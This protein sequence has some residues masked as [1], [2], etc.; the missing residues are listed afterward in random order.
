VTPPNLDPC[1]DRLQAP[2]VAFTLR[3]IGLVHAA[4][5]RGARIPKYLVPKG[6]ATLEVFHPY[7]PGL[8]GLYAGS[9]V[10]VVTWHA[11]ASRSHADGWSDGQ[12]LLGVFATSSVERPNPLEFQRARVVDLDTDK[13][14]LRV[15]GL[16]AEDGAPILDIR[17]ALTPHHRLDP[18]RG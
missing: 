1:P 3:P 6:R 11:P 8:Q 13:G 12:G 15:E 17:P 10:W 18:P 16:D 2:T 4:P 7:A 5:R 9:D 14:L